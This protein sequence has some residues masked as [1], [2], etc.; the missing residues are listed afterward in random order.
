MCDKRRK[1]NINIEEVTNG[2][3]IERRIWFAKG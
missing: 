2:N 1:N 3:T